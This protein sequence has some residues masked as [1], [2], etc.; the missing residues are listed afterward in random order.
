MSKDFAYDECLLCGNSILKGI[1]FLSLLRGDNL[2]YLCR[3]ELVARPRKSNYN[4]YPLYTLYEYDNVSNLLIRYK[5]YL[6]IPLATIFVKPYINLINILFKGYT[7][8]L[9]PSSESMETR[10]G[11]NHLK[12]MLVGCKLSIVDCLKKEDHIQRFSK[13][14]NLQFE[15]K[16]DVSLSKVIIFDD[17]ITS[18]NSMQAALDLIDPIASKVILFSVINNYKRRC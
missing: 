14:R 13:D 9:I 5:D 12:N 3:K 15:F 8:V 4:G 18:G 11:F 6:D 7:I 10:R 17:V 1:S 2:C 16:E